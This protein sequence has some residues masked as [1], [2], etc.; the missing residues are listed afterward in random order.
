VINIKLVN[1]TKRFGAITAVNNMSL[2]IRRGELFTILGPTGA[3]KTTTLK[4]IAG[5]LNPDE[6]EIYFDGQLVNDLPPEE[7]DVGFVFQGYA[8]F[9]HMTVW[10]NVTYGPLVRGMDPEEVER[11]GREIL[12]KVHL[13]E[14][15]DSYPH[16]L[17]GGM[18]QRV[19]LARA[20]ASGS[21]LLLLDEPLSALDARLREELRFELRNIVKEVGATA[22]QVTHDKYEAL[23][24]SDRIAILR[25]GKVVQV[26][27]PI[28]L[29]TKP[30]S[31]FVANFICDM[32]FLEGIVK[33]VDENG[34]VVELRGGPLVRTLDRTHRAGERVVVAVR[35]E[36]VEI[37]PGETNYS[38]GIYG[39][40]ERISFLGPFIRIEIILENGEEVSV[41]L[42]ATIGYKFEL[43]D[44]VTIYFEP[45]KIIVYS[46][47]REGLAEELI[48][49]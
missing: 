43:G 15:A 6:G 28:N 10:E 27:T 34:S 39:R 44:R 42:P 19:A 25:K 3:G 5:L 35:F 38:Y 14:R 29:F 8:L 49:E 4:L 16:E 24:L 12:S 46:Y 23:Q 47:P 30:N 40:I 37:K 33:K 36:D 13:L 21:K 1:V 26:D 9:P 32:N 17:S 22:I 20:L 11:I 2:E 45:S 48:V 41:K 31:I 18:Q 7:R